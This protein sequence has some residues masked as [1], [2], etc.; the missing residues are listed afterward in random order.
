MTK[1]DRQP[2]TDPLA[3]EPARILNA[4]LELGEQHGWDA[5]HLHQIAQVLGITLVDIR[6]HF[7]HKDAIAEAWFDLADQALLKAPQ[8]PDWVQ[9]NPRE[10]LHKAI[11][12]WLDALATHRQLTAA[13]LRYKFQPDHLHLQALGLTR[14]S[15][16][17]QWIRE[18][19]ALPSAGWLREVQEVV[20]TG[21]YLSTFATWLR[22]DSAGAARTHALL[23]RLLG[24]AEQVAL[25][26]SPPG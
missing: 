10:R 25:R 20:L 15:R 18:V 13:M 19:A 12:A 22:D 9:L 5:L 4:A 8:H 7:E 3:G 26:L 14:V 16:T 21:I 11:F 1:S 2:S 17:V 6:M 23:D 24:V